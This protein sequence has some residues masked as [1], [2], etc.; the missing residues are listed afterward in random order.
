MSRPPHPASVASPISA[1]TGAA[2][3]RAPRGGPADRA[4][5]EVQGLEVVYNHAALAV[6]GV[7]LA[8]RDGQ[9]VALLGTNGAGKTTTLRAISGFLGS[10]IADITQGSIAYEGE[11]IDGRPPYE[12]A[13]R[14]VALVPER[15]KI[16]ETLTVEENLAT[17]VFAARSG[18]PSRADMLEQV[19]GYFP[20]LRER[21]RQ[22]AGYLSGGERQMLAISRALLCGPRLLLVDE[23]SLGLAPRV[24]AEL[25]DI[26]QRLR[27]DLG[28]S[29]L[30]VEENAA[31]ALEI[32]D[33]GYVMEHGRIVFE[34]TAEALRQHADIR[35]F[36]LGFGQG[37][38]ER[39]YRDVK[40]YRRKRRWH[41]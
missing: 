16:F 27:A 36:Y 31:A 6:Q 2:E 40:Q 4:L 28:L 9:I 10:D 24:A 23:L 8:V 1:G 17:S 7:S 14:G 30:L 25:L 29:I 35:E 34:D 15:E 22:V 26:L 37:G 18:A 21:R 41:G 11:R 19:F 33:R 20:I 5:L 38:G 13:R 3:G 39:S 32:A 12:I